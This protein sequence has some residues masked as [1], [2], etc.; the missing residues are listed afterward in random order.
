MPKISIIVLQYNK[1]E[2]TL[3]CL[4]SVAKL[5]YPNYEVIVVDNASETKHLKNVEY[6]IDLN[7]AK[8]YKLIDNSSN[9]GYG[10]GNNVSIKHALKN[11]ADYVL[12]LNNDTVI[13]PDFLDNIPDA[14]ISGPTIHKI[15]W[16]YPQGFPNGDISDKNSYIS[17]S[18]ILV[19][20]EVFEKIGL[21]DES[22]FLYFEDADFCFRARRAGF[23]LSGSTTK[24]IHNESATV[25]EMG[26]EKK[27]LLNARNARKF[28]S[29]FAPWYIR[30]LLPFWF[31]VAIL[32]IRIYANYRRRVRINWG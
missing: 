16:L 11:G 23:L 9:L 24:L 3:R 21:I 17:G 31:P 6:W 32:Y 18:A 8:S 14:D 4:E 30:L 15:K 13:A 28:F 2:Y 22:Y 26:L 1:S 19:K 5:N 7:Q 20:K 10:A 27:L 12:I 25:R 29:R